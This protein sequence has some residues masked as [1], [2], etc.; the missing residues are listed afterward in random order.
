MEDTLLGKVYDIL[1]GKERKVECYNGQGDVTLIDCYPRLCP[2]GRTLDF[3]AVRSARVSYGS[4]LKSVKADE[5]LVRYLIQNRHTSPLEFAGFTFKVTCPLF[6]ARQIMRHRTTS[7]NEISARYTVLPNTI[8]KV[9]K[10]GLRMNIVENKQSSAGQIGDEK[11]EEALALF[12][13]VE[14]TSYESYEKLLKLGVARE[15]ARSV[16]PVGIFTEFYITMNLNNFLKFLSLRLPEDC[17]KETREVAEAMFCL[18]Q[19]LSPVVFNTFRDGLE[20]M[21]LGKSE[22]ESILG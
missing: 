3:A 13:K 16:L 12:K 4:G 17:Q 11:A 9:T 10:E 1:N 5:G 22:V 18:A 8:F 7:I 19:P 2:E 6:V 15:V 14:E 20:G 21:F